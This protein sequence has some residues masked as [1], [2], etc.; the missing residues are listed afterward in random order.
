VNK[1]Q[2][3]FLGVGISGTDFAPEIIFSI[4]CLLEKSSIRPIAAIATLDKRRGHPLLAT[5]SQEFNAEILLFP[6]RVL[7]AQRPR[8][9]NPQPSLYARIGCH[10]V[11]EAAS[12]AA[13]GEQAKLVIPK[14]ICHKVTF[15][16]AG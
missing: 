9:A 2:C 14:T 13:A 16:V 8:L 3:F 15:A 4:K 1:A 11:A 6:V 5:L 7:A 12:L 10:G